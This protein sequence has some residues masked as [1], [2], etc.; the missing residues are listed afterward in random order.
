MVLAK[1]RTQLCLKTY[2]FLI[3]QSA[4]PDDILACY[5]RYCE[6]APSFSGDF[7]AIA[8]AR[9]ISL[10]ALSRMQPR[11]VE[12]EAITGPWNRLFGEL[13][14]SGGRAMAGSLAALLRRSNDPFTAPE[15]V[16]ELLDIVDS[17]GL[18]LPAY[19]RREIPGCKVAPGRVLVSYTYRGGLVGVSW[20]WRIGEPGSNAAEV[21]TE[22]KNFNDAVQTEYMF[23]K[24]DGGRVGVGLAWAVP[25][26][27]WPFV[28]YRVEAPDE[29]WVSKEDLGAAYKRYRAQQDRLAR[30]YAKRS[31]M[32]WKRT[33]MR[34]MPG[35]FPDE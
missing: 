7:A 10:F 17:C 33:R 25:W 15:H 9:A 1:S 19:L 31:G 5:A 34:S 32:R 26:E 6:F 22:Y 12:P 23:L 29:G 35:E 14:R 13:V 18:D 27:Y 30:R 16:Q 4:G 21:L 3:F 8:E 24:P 28:F 11:A 20:E 2:R